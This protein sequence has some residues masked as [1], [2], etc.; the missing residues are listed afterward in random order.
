MGKP[1]PLR[2]IELPRQDPPKV[3]APVRIRNFRAIYRPF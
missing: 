2:F 3:T 1:D